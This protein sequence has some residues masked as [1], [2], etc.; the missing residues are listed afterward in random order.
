MATSTPSPPVAARIC[1]T[2]SPSWAETICHAPWDFTRESFSRERPT[3]STRPPRRRRGHAPPARQAAVAVD[4]QDLDV[5]TQ[6]R[7]PGETEGAPVAGDGQRDQD[8]VAG[9]DPGDPGPHL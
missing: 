6:L 5:R 9:G 2:R 7:L 8:P 1:S 4:A 3:A